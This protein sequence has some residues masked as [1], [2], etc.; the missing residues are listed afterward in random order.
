MTTAKCRFS[1][2]V[3]A[4]CLPTA[5]SKVTRSS[6]LDQTPD[7][8]ASDGGSTGTFV[9]SPDSQSLT[10]IDTSDDLTDAPVDH[11]S[12]SDGSSPG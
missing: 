5:S 10:F 4:T 3:P 8:Q 9:F 2:R 1:T 7:G 6:L 12:G 11:G